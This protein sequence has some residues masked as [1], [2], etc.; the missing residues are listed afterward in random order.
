M[1]RIEIFKPN[2]MV[3]LHQTIVDRLILNR[4]KRAVVKDFMPIV[5]GQLDDATIGY[6]I[7]ESGYLTGLLIQAEEG[8]CVFAIGHWSSKKVLCMGLTAHEGIIVESELPGP[9]N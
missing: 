3:V 8:R 9:H 5:D 4:S 7:T 6:G 1:K 2:R